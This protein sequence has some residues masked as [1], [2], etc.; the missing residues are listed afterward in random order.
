MRSHVVAPVLL[1]ALFVGAFGCMGTSLADAAAPGSL[2]ADAALDQTADIPT[3][4]D[5]GIDQ[6]DAPPSDGD[7]PESPVDGHDD[8]AETSET[9]E[10]VCCPTETPT[11]D[12][13]SL[14]GHAASVSQCPFQR[15]CDATPINWEMGTDSFG[16][17]QWVKT[18]DPGDSC[19]RP[20]IDS[21]VGF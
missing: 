3:A 7:A 2:G 10:G 19:L 11:C 15:I 1:A 5:L 16:C 12:C 17:A 18:K 4:H 13:F 6:A 14:G 8:V 9:S 20:P 21:G